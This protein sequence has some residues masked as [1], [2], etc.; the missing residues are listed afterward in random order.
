M[1][2]KGRKKRTNGVKHFK[3]RQTKKEKK[4]SQH[5]QWVEA[6]QAESD[7]MLLYGEWY[8]DKQ[9]IT[10]IQREAYL[11]FIKRFALATTGRVPQSTETDDGRT[12]RTGT[13]GL[14]ALQ[15]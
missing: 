8:A 14:E 7:W 12:E 13:T 2:R 10:G 9:G 15:G 3:K 6:Q 4:V 11:D 5:E 1:A